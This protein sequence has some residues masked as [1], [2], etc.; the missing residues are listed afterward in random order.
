MRLSL[1]SVALV[2]LVASLAQAHEAVP[3]PPAR[4]GVLECQGGQN[5]GQFVTSITSLDCVFRSEGR[6]PESYVATIRRY[7]VDLGITAETKMAWAVNAPTNQF[8]RGELAGRYGGVTAN[9][10]VGVGFGGN[11]LVGGP[12]NAYVL[13]P[14]SLQGQTGLNVAAGAADL[15]LS[16][17][18]LVHQSPSHR[19]HHHHRL[20]R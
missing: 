8:G 5:V 19:M 20:H 16:P 10:S 9:A 6:R 14:I 12:S 17:V 15:E 3:M 11:F 4:A 1:L 13:Q 18:M 7:G 2:S